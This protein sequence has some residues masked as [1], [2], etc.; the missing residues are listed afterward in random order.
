MPERLIL[1]E[2]LLR[3]KPALDQAFHVWAKAAC[4]TDDYHL[5]GII[6]SSRVST[7][8]LCLNLSSTTKRVLRLDLL[9]RPCSYKCGNRRLA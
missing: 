5:E 2:R 6:G 3:C 9:S 1:W 4:E 8:T 7:F